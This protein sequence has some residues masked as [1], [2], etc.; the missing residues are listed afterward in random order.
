MSSDAAA[1]VVCVGLTTVDVTQRVEGSLALG[2]KHQSVATYVDVGG[3]AANA[4][5]TAAHLGSSVVLHTMLGVGPMREFAQSVLAK[6]SVMVVDH[7][8]T[9]SN[10]QLPVSSVLVDGDG[11]RTVVSSNG[12]AAPLPAG[13]GCVEAPPD[14][15][16]IDGHHLPLAAAVVEAAGDAV[17]VLD[18]GSWKPGLEGLLARV[19][20]AIVSEAWDPPGAAAQV[21][22]G[23]RF[24]AHTAGDEPVVLLTDKGR[25]LLPVARVAAVDTSGAGDVLHGAF[26]HHMVGRPL[27][28]AA[29]SRALELAMTVATG[30]CLHEGAMGWVADRT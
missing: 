4:A 5:R 21:A 29:V 19:D 20:V 9:G 15:V 22:A 26:A 7:T 30:S 16:L 24:R 12:A 11:E 17:V 6:D 25:R 28:S 23:V 3:P 1:D 10:W 13:F 14:V 2:L 27:S 8:P 18:G